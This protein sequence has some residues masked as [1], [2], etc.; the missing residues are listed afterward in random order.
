MRIHTVALV[1]AMVVADA[2]EPQL[3]ITHSDGSVDVHV[4]FAPGTDLPGPAVAVFLPDDLREAA[5]V[6]DGAVVATL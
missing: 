6:V 5:L 3:R 1:V 2:V 4:L